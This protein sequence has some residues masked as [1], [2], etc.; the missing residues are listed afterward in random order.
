MRLI[1]HPF[2][3]G[4]SSVPRA[5]IALIVA[6]TAAFV[7]IPLPLAFLA[8]SGD[9]DGEKSNTDPFAILPLLGIGYAITMA[10]SV[11][12]GGLVWIGLRATENESGRAYTIAGAILGL[13]VAAQ[14]GFTTLS[15]LF[16]PSAPLVIGLCI[17][18]GALVALGFWL[19]AREAPTPE[20]S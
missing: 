7:L 2:A 12:G 14:L 4:R 11:V 8:F 19:I 15:Q 9:W 6:P 1:S 13:V 20:P 16:N 18:I 17:F 10:I 3:P 5:L